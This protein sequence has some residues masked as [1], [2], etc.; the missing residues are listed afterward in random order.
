MEPIKRI[1]WRTI[2]RRPRRGY[3]NTKPKQN[4]IV[5]FSSHMIGRKV[6][7]I[8]LEQ[9]HKLLLESKNFTRVKKYIKFL[10]TRSRS[11]KMK[12]NRRKK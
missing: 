11:G 5:Y 7:S 10:D 3:H 8:T 6:V 1:R 9:Y 4:G 12:T 2:R